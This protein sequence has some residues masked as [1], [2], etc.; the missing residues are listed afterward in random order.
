VSLRGGGEA[1]VRF[2]GIDVADVDVRGGYAVVEPGAP[3]VVRAPVDG[4]LSITVRLRAARP[5]RSSR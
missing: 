1:A 2:D 5:P 4:W 3:C